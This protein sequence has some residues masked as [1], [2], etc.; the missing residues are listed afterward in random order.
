MKFL[1]L[2]EEANKGRD[3]IQVVFMS[4]EEEL[5]KVMVTE[6]QMVCTELQASM[7][8]DLLAIGV[9]LASATSLWARFRFFPWWEEEE[10]RPDFDALLERLENSG[11][12]DKVLADRPVN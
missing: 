1:R 4:P 12:L 6:N 2:V 8:Q 10:R 3:L 5:S 11:Q 9:I 7:D